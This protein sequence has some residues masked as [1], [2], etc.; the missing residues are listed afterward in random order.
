MHYHSTKLVQTTTYEVC[1]DQL[2]PS[3]PVQGL[4]KSMADITKQNPSLLS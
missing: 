4:V 2:S 1:A 3:F